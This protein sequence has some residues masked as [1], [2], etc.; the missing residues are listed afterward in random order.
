MINGTGSASFVSPQS[1]TSD[2]RIGPNVDQFLLHCENPVGKCPQCL[3]ALSAE[4][5][6][7]HA[8]IYLCH[9]LSLTTVMNTLRLKTD[10]LI[11]AR[12][13]VYPGRCDQSLPP[14]DDS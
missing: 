9:L 14:L 12:Q 6:S 2:L 13:L 7:K 8:P 1:E 5:L 4:P 10:K 3:R 11:P